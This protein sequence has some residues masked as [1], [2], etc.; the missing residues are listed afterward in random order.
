MGVVELLLQEV[1]SR[2]SERKVEVEV[3]ESAKAELVKETRRA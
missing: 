3:T 1:A 2:L